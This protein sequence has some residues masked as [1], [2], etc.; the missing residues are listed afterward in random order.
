MKSTALVLFLACAAPVTL[1]ADT[2]TITGIVSDTTC[3]AKHRTADA[4]TC[5]RDCVSKGADYALVVNGDVYTVKADTSLKEK[6]ARRVGKAAV[7]RGDL[8]GMVITATRVSTP[9][10]ISKH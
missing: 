2:H 10:K 8:E 3:G 7:V 5:A 4:R 1:W 9:K 6:L